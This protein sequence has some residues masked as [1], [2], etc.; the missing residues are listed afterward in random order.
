[1]KNNK[2]EKELLI[3]FINFLHQNNYEITYSP[4]VNTYEKIKSGNDEEESIV[5]FDFILK[6][7]SRDRLKQEVQIF[8]TTNVEGN[9]TS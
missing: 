3:D 9:V 2:Y 1:M 4:S 7:P 8:V 5:K 6:K